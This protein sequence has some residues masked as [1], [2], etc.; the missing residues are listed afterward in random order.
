M[1]E[2]FVVS[3]WHLKLQTQPSKMR[4]NKFYIL[5]LDYT[6]NKE[7]SHVTLEVRNRFS[8]KLLLTASDKY[9][10]LS[11]IT[12]LLDRTFRIYTTTEGRDYLLRKIGKQSLEVLTIV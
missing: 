2:Q 5:N 11:N 10:V 7:K 8:K 1:P 12:A 9:I 4:D 6:Q 3:L